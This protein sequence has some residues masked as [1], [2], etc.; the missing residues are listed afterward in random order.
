[1]VATRSSD[2]AAAA[3]ASPST[4][5]QLA[6]RSRTIQTSTPNSRVSTPSGS[7]RKRA[8]PAASGPTDSPRPKRARVIVSN[9]LGGKPDPS[10]KSDADSNI[11][12]T[13]SIDT[14]KSTHVS[15]DIPV[16]QI[17]RQHKRF[18]SQERE[19]IDEPD[20][21]P[22]TVREKDQSEREDDD[23]AP[24][25]E[26]TRRT[27]ARARGTKARTSRSAKKTSPHG[28]DLTLTTPVSKFK[29]VSTDVPASASTTRSFQTANETMS[30]NEEDDTVLVNDNSVYAHL[31]ESADMSA[32]A[33][34]EISDSDT[35]DDT[36]IIRLDLV[37][38]HNTA[39]AVQGTP[40]ATANTT[41]PSSTNTKITFS[42]Q[43]DSLAFSALSPTASTAQPPHHLP[44]AR[45]AINHA[46]SQPRPQS[47][48]RKQPRH[49]TSLSSFR[50]N[51]IHRRVAKGTFRVQTSWDRR[52][53]KFAV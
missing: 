13:D 30:D 31:T 6:L 41:Q 26:S 50:A 7:A 16:A 19:E 34:Q 38:E 39:K 37:A 1:M 44:S 23:A 14:T 45:P 27:P 3:A 29:D 22:S 5:N 33:R 18:G 10:A 47:H 42:D 21:Q 15:V 12:N 49:N 36:T 2:A 52:R 28:Q 25:V 20:L 40:T 24:E 35:M 4:T 43:D 32:P 9:A 11:E 51:I 46:V 8:P 53:H 48:P 17:T